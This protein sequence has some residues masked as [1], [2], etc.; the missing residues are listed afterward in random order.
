MDEYADLMRILFETNALMV[1]GYIA[2]LQQF[3]LLPKAPESILEIVFGQ[4]DF[5]ILLA[6]AYPA[7]D[8]VGIGM[9]MW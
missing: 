8:V 5:S 3:A 6:Q 9:A 1:D 7:A 4:G 2:T